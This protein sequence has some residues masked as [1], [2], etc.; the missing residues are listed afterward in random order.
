MDAGAR[1]FEGEMWTFSGSPPTA[2]VRRG[3]GGGTRAHKNALLFHLPRGQ[4][5]CADKPRAAV[6]G[7]IIMQTRAHK[8][9]AKSGGVRVHNYAALG[10]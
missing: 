9:A 1:T 8:N 10:A 7:R 4:P 5:P 6:F 3:Y 2:A